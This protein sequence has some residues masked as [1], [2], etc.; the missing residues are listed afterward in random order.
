MLEYGGLLA[1]THFGY[2]AAGVQ[3]CRDLEA[4]AVLPYPLRNLLQKD[5]G[6]GSPDGLLS[7]VCRQKL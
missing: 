1:S 7:H 3:A 4:L 2:A 5:A 6:T